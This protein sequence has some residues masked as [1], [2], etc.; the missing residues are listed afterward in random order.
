[1]SRTAILTLA[2]LT[3][4]ASPAA[5]QTSSDIR[6]EASSRSDPYVRLHIDRDWDDV[7][8]DS[9]NWNMRLDLTAE[10]GMTVDAIDKGG[11]VSFNYV[12][13]AGR[14]DCTGKAEDQRATGN[15]TF[16]VNDAFAKVL[17][18]RGVVRPTKYQ[19]YG[20]A[21]S[22]IDSDVIDAVVQEKMGIPTPNE[23]ISLGIFKV[24]PEFVRGMAHLNGMDI[25]ISDLVQFRIF[26]I[27]PENAKDYASLGYGKLTPH[28]LVQFSIFHVA[29]E[30]IRSFKEAGYRDLTS[31]DLQQFSMFHVT[32]DYMKELA[33]LGYR[34]VP[35]ATLVRMKMFGVTANFVRNMNEGAKSKLSPEELVQRR[36][37][38]ARP[39][40][41]YSWSEGRSR[42]RGDRGAQD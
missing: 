14:F 22:G 11:P 25:R 13:P 18:A 16:T 1:M 27:T 28:D 8:G 29:P 23:L 39:Q 12:R 3:T 10:K 24:T 19:Y 31:H 7:H 40:Y 26:K 6:F 17:A 21:M 38:G 41:S 30:T 2:L 5:A 42:Q 36:L 37:S 32:P 35:A 4:A 34:N 15:C 20:L 33:E 9:W